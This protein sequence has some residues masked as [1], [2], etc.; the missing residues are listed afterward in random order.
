MFPDGALYLKLIV[1]E[2]FCK[3]SNHR[4]EVEVVRV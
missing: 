2:R 4:D 1:N 3:T